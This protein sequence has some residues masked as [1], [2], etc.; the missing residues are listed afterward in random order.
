MI[1][2]T[3]S[4]KLLFG[5]GLCF[6][7]QAQ[8][9]KVE[10]H[11]VSFPKTDDPEPLELLIGE[12]ET[13]EVQLPTNHIS[14]A[15]SVPHLSNWELGKS[16]GPD[17]Q[18]FTF[19]SYGKTPSISSKSQLVLVIRRDSDNASGLQL[20]PLDYS[21]SGFT[22][23]EYF[24]MNATKVDV[25]G[26]IGSLKFSLK[27]GKHTLVTPEPSKTRDD[28]DYSYARFFFRQDDTA[29][30]FFSAT[31]R[32][33][34]RARSMVFFYHDPRTKQIRLHIIRSFLPST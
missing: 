21:D 2:F 32:L 6:A 26:I 17:A 22:G 24:F 31:W 28:R 4:M 14:Q 8:N 15:Y 34:Q 30:P 18:E 29:Q 5:L 33:N 10:L 13:L 3:H 25:A 7:L 16:S 23:G 27:P 1:A 11:F 20:V 9:E 19:Q 12:N